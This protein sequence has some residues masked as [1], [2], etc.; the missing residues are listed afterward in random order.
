MR[1]FFP[2]FRRGS[3]ASA[4]TRLRLDSCKLCFQAEESK[5]TWLRTVVSLESIRV[6]GPKSPGRTSWEWPPPWCKTSWRRPMRTPYTCSGGEPKCWTSPHRP[7]L[8][9]WRAFRTR[10]FRVRTRCSAARPSCGRFRRERCGCCPSWAELASLWIVLCWLPC[11][12]S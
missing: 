4:L 7:S 5:L 9:C 11:R 3:S 1:N 6:R 8:R 2:L 10:S 12:S